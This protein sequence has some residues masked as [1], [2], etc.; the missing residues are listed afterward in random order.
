MVLSAFSTRALVA[1]LLLLAA[2]QREQPAKQPTAR[3]NTFPLPDSS[4]SAVPRALSPMEQAHARL[5]VLMAAYWRRPQPALLN[6]IDRLC[7]RSDGEL[8]TDCG[9]A[10]GEL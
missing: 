6:A 3:P 4:T 2:C 9:I 5:P 7:C 1:A 8:S 10:T